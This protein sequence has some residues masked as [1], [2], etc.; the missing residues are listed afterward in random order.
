MTTQTL[1]ELSYQEVWYPVLGFLTG[2]K[3]DRI[4]EQCPP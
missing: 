3:I 4:G 1:I 2:L